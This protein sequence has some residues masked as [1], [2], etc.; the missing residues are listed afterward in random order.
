MKQNNLNYRTIGIYFLIVTMT[1]GSIDC[2]KDKTDNTPLLATLYAMMSKGTPAVAGAVSNTPIATTTGTAPTNAGQAV[3]PTT[4]VSAGTAT[5][6]ANVPVA[7]KLQ[8]VKDVPLTYTVKASAPTASMLGKSNPSLAVTAANVSITLSIVNENGDTLGTIKSV[9]GATTVTLVYTPSS[10]ITLV[11]IINADSPMIIKPEV[12]G[13]SQVPLSQP[14]NVAEVIVSPTANV[15]L[16]C[17]VL[18][19]NNTPTVTN[20]TCLGGKV[21]DSKG[22]LTPFTTFDTATVT[23]GTSA[24]ITLTYYPNPFGNTTVGSPW[25]TM[26]TPIWYGSSKT[27]LP[28]AG[29]DVKVRLVKTSESIDFTQTLKIPNLISNVTVTQNGASQNLD[30]VTN[31]TIDRSLDA[32]LKWTVPTTNPPSGVTAMIGKMQIMQF[33]VV[34]GSGTSGTMTVPASSLAIL[35][36]SPLDGDGFS[37]SS[38]FNSNNWTALKYYQGAVT[39]DKGTSAVQMSGIFVG[40]IANSTTKEPSVS[41]GNSWGGPYTQNTYQKLTVK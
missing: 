2:K 18:F 19:Y 12:T 37:L 22:T 38:M 26:T 33:N 40:G 11:I 1:L 41:E 27:I 9:P 21:T 29:D 28:S 16:N 23:V 5:L 34:S 8:A 4:T 32:I 39:D 7:Q 6:Q 25:N 15:L 35:T 14:Q 31:V 20:A 36:V 30:G 3:S 10:T 13:V 17:M 24:A